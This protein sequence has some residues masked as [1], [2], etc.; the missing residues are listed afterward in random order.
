VRPA[1]PLAAERQRD[2]G[3][4]VFVTGRH[5]RHELEGVSGK[6][7]CCNRL[8]ALDHAS[9]PPNAPTPDDLNKGK[10][11]IRDRARAP[12]HPWGVGP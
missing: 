11:G 3:V 5:H 2:A 4:L 6:I 10:K 9:Q 1:H 8:Y 7:T 12:R